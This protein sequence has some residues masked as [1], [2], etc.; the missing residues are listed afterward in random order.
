MVIVI[1]IMLPESDCAAAVVASIPNAQ[2]ALI[3]SI[4]K[5][6]MGTLR[7]IWEELRHDGGKPSGRP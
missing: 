4:E 3:R 2:R 5:V 6:D 7:L 1:V